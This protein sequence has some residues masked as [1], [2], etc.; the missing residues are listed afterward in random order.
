MLVAAM[1]KTTQKLYR[2]RQARCVLGKCGAECCYQSHAMC[3][4]SMGKVEAWSLELMGD[5]DS[6]D[7]PIVLRWGVS[8]KGSVTL[9]C[10]C[11]ASPAYYG[12]TTC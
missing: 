7:M 6:G 2:S 1:L 8:D 3:E 4:E 10:W 12:I 5:V 11:C 9:Y